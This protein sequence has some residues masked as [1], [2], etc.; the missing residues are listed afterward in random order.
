MRSHVSSGLVLALALLVLV[1]TRSVVLVQGNGDGTVSVEPQIISVNVGGSFSVDIWIR[2][3]PY[4]MESWGIDLTWNP[5]MIGYVSYTGNLPNPQ[6]T[7]T[8]SMSSGKLEISASLMASGSGHT[9]DRR[10]LTIN[11]RCLGAGVSQLAIPDNGWMDASVG[12]QHSFTVQ[13]STVRQTSSSVGGVILAGHLATAL[14]PYLALVGL[15]A[16]TAIA[17]KTKRRQ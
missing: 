13:Q 17:I 4:G 2:G 15:A 11:F 6:W 10:W 12:A 14:A 8:V 16:S 7:L 1:G 5:N 3:L 9:A